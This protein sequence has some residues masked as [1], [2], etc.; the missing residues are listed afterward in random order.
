MQFKVTYSSEAEM[1]D[2]LLDDPR[3]ARLILGSQL[4]DRVS[5]SL[6]YYKREVYLGPYG[7][8]DAIIVSKIHKLGLLSIDVIEFKNVPLQSSHL[9][10]LSRYVTGIS[11]IQKVLVRGHLVGPCLSTEDD[12][13]FLAQESLLRVWTLESYHMNKFPMRLV[14]G[15][16]KI[17]EDHDSSMESL[18][19]SITPND[20]DLNYGNL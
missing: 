20:G 14:Q 2:D 6:F 8:A 10:Q 5:R 18:T 17:R 4:E 13:C 11:R 3:F 9:A 7:R 12:F 15:W 16:S 19:A 1:V